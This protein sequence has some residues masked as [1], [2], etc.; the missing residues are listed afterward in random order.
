MKQTNHLFQAFR[1]KTYAFFGGQCN[2]QVHWSQASHMVDRKS[3]SSSRIPT[4]SLA[5]EYNTGYLLTIFSG[6]FPLLA[7]VVLA[8]GQVIGKWCWRSGSRGR[9]HSCL[10]VLSLDHLVVLPVLQV[11]SQLCILGLLCTMLWCVTLQHKR[12]NLLNIKD[13]TEEPNFN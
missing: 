8:Q 7:K 12:G 4:N 3:L 5:G 2:N 11:G 13:C 9:S 6:E 10:L 1:H